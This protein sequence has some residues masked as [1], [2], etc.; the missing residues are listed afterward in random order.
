VVYIFPIRYA[1]KVAISFKIIETI[2]EFLLIFFQVYLYQADI[3][4]SDCT[5]KIYVGISIGY[6]QGARGVRAISYTP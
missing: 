6:M 5:K 2:K 3:Y 4:H 1:I